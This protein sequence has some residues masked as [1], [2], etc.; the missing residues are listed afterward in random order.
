MRKAYPKYK[1]SGIEWLGEIPEHWKVKKLKY[2]ARIQTGNTPP[3]SDPNNYDENGIPWIKPDDIG[4]FI[5][6]N[7]SAECLSPQGAKLA[8]LIPQDAV[9][10]CA[11]PRRCK[12]LIF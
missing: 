6:V 5:P 11:H 8:R 4:N 10:V 3:R 1:D 9:L 2:L 7:S 12:D